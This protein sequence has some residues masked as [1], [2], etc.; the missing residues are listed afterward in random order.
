M[1]AA[2]AVALAA[3]SVAGRLSGPDEAAEAS[4]GQAP[5]LAYGAPEEEA[6]GI[7]PSEDPDTGEAVLAAEQA[8]RMN[9]LLASSSSSRADLPEAID[10]TI[11]CEQ[12]G[13]DAIEGI[14]ASR[15]DQLASAR[16]LDVDA[17]PGGADLKDALV[18]ALDASF[19]ADAALLSWARRH[20]GDCGGSVSEDR[21][22]KRGLAISR[23]ARKAKARFAEAW[24]PIAETHD[25]TAWKPSQF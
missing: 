17:L 6:G 24:R 16:G 4:Q 23:D 22:Y 3:W 14:T 19:D 25:L 8:G 11:K 21:D 20:V 18:D 12:G 9:E 10:R 5:A 2:L 15:R 7:E 1:I 13:L